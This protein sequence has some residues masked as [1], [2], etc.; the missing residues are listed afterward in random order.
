MV[1][2]SD[3]FLNK[4]KKIKSPMTDLGSFVYYRTYSRFIESEQRREYWW[5]TVKRVVEYN[6]NLVEGVSNEEAEKLFD[7][8]FS[9]RQF[10]SGR[11]L[12]VGGTESSRK[13]PMSNFN[14]SFTT[15]ESIDDICDVFYL[16]L[17]G[18]GVGFRIFPEDVDKLPQIN[19]YISIEHLPYNELKNKATVTIPIYYKD[20]CEIFIGDSKEGWV[21]A[22]RLF[23]NIIT[24]TSELT[25]YTIKI[26]YN[27]IRK[28]GEILKTFGGTAS[29][30]ESMKIM[31]DRIFEISQNTGDKFSTIDC[32]D[33]CNLVGNNVLTGGVRRVA[34]IG[35]FDVDDVKVRHAKNNIYDIGN[36]HLLHRAN[37]NNSIIFTKKPSKEKLREIFESIKVSGEPAFV[38]G[39]T[40][41][42]RFPEFKGVNPCVEILLPN[43]GLC[44]L[45]TINMMS[46]LN[47][48]NE[49]D[50]VRLE[51]LCRLGSRV[52][53]RMACV[54]LELKN[55]DKVQKEHML[56]GC[57][58][59]GWQDFVNATNINDRVKK[60]ILNKMKK[61]I[62]NEAKIYSQELGFNEPNMT[63]CLK[64]E[65][66]LS[67][68]PT[69]SAG[70]HFSH[71]PYYIRRVR[72][73][74]ND[75]IVK[76]CE[77][78]NWTLH[79]EGN[80]KVV[81]FPC[82]AP[83][84]KTKYDISAV[85]QLEIYRMFMDEYVE[86]NASNTIT[87]RNNEWDN[88]VDWIYSNW[89]NFVGVSFLSLDDTF[90]PLAPYEKISKEKYEELIKDRK[91]FDPELLNKYIKQESKDEDLGSDCAGGACPIR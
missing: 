47:K 64:P 1:S 16:M 39:E 74:A 52:S 35:L 30:Y 10:P 79:D 73:S 65:G 86:M 66:T 19:K 57:S 6:C 48:K 83:E 77:E 28:K 62:K 87:V 27:S 5:E 80:N 90:Y 12:W 71:S 23:L 36:E 85:E 69:V 50:F 25:P 81:D 91:S 31:F 59:T 17:L 18:T 22:L 88:V 46:V 34:G 9:L 15:I 53:Y 51:E 78:L 4:Y 3:K 8:I 44:N 14:C 37:S 45:T 72:V 38:N 32:L 33:I 2:L 7:N 60:E 56:L 49:I 40:A 76:V 82:K 67:L 84:G 42:R 20:S 26:N 63:T 41:L 58:L 61:W 21:E 55:W 75:P 11:S 89:D 70:L 43:K 54:K 24:D 13:F 68:L 29:G